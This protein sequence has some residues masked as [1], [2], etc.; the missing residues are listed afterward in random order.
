VRFTCEQLLG[1]AF[2]KGFTYKYPKDP[3]FETAVR[4]QVNK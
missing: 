2:F 3:E 4:F 1:H